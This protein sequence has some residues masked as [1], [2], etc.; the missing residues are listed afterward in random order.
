MSEHLRAIL[1]QV[2]ALPAAER[3]ELLGEVLQSLDD[4]ASDV[5]ATWTLEIRKRLEALRA[6]E[7]ELVDWADAREEI[8]GSSQ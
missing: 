4:S 2:L 3:V 1:A 6:G 7:S 5:E 8:Q